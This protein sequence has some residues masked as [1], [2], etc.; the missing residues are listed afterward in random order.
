MS[1]P[2]AG[3]RTVGARMP[4]P[5]LSSLQHWPRELDPARAQYHETFLVVKIAR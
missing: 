3:L 4:A 5:T 2:G 1:A